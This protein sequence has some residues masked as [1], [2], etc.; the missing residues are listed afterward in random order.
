MHDKTKAEIDAELEVLYAQSDDLFSRSSEALR[1]AHR[2]SH[3]LRL[4]ISKATNLC[5]ASSSLFEHFEKNYRCKSHS[6]S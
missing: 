1:Q 5:D 6:K 2:E 4:L 3:Y